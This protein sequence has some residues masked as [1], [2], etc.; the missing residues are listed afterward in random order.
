VR[1]LGPLRFFR[2][3]P[4]VAEKAGTLVLHRHIRLPVE[5]RHLRLTLLAVTLLVVPVVAQRPDSPETQPGHIVGTVTDVNNDPIPRATVVLDGP[6]PIDRRMVVTNDNG[7]FDLHD[8][9][10][11]IPYQVTISAK[12][13]A[14]WTSSVALQPG[15]YTVLESKLRI[16]EVRT[17]V[18]VT[19]SSEEI[20][21][22]Q[23]R[24]EV[25]Q[26]VF[27]IIPNFYVVYDPNPAP[28]TTKLKFK[29]AFKVVTDPITFLGIAFLSGVQ[30][31][32]DTPDY[33]QGAAG[34]GE[35]F[36]AN[37]A[38]AF[39][40]VMIG[41][42]IL[43]SLLHQDPRYFYQRTG[44]NKSRARHALL[45]PFVCKGDNGKWQPNYSSLGGDLASSAISNAYYPK[46]NRGL[47]LT[48][49]NFA[50]GT[51]ERAV[52]GLLQEFVMGKLTHGR[53]AP[54]TR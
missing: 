34:Y 22:Q 9:R 28:L 8:V 24:A 46:S 21:A 17:T 53:P 25:Q 40:D 52:S 5:A 39:T 31:A 50:T 16:E 19:P 47:G 48:F 36:G 6:V 20:A 14:A 11:G 37:T 18:T 1:S 41:G 38:D 29:L 13:F 44:T 7:F 30:Q 49:G 45:S 35:R 43:P 10:P 12:G 26:R 32:G 15:Q 23:V 33:G 51:A 2:K 42:A 4:S 27:G 3:L 54:G